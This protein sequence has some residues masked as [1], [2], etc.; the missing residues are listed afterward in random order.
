MRKFAT[1]LLAAVIAL[2][3]MGAANGCDPQAH[4]PGGKG[5]GGTINAQDGK[6]YISEI[7]TWQYGFTMAP[8]PK[9]PQCKWEVW[10]LQRDGWKQLYKG[11][12]IGKVKLP[13][14]GVYG[15]AYLTSKSCGDW[16]PW[17]K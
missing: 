2:L 7:G 10:G 8:S 17:N 3:T 6:H 16:D 9:F 12:G 14:A 5:G 15:S 4:Q 13:P 1:L 11:H